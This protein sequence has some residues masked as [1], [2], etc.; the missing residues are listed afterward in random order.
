MGVSSS[1][2]NLQ[3]KSKCVSSPIAM[4]PAASPTATHFFFSCWPFCSR[5]DR[6]NRETF[7][8]TEVLDLTMP[9]EA[10]MRVLPVAGRSARRFL[11]RNRWAFK[12]LARSLESA[13]AQL[14]E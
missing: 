9:V 14:S 3:N 8:P 4:G 6:D 2:S 13:I 11:C 12:A 10:L 7:H 1:K 5:C